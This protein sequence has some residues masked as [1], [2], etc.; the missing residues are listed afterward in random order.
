MPDKLAGG[1]RIVGVGTHDLAVGVRIEIFNGERLHFRKHFLTQLI[2][3]TLRYRRHDSM[4]EESRDDH[5]PVR[6]SHA[7]HHAHE[8]PRDFAQPELNPR[9]D[10]LVDK[11]LHEHR[12]HQTAERVE[13]NTNKHDNHAPLIMLKQ[14]FKQPPERAFFNRA[15]RHGHTPSAHG[16]H[17]AGLLFDRFFLCHYASPPCASL[18]FVCIS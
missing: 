11:R 9:R 16:F 5:D 6:A 18:P 10:N 12:R 14:H 3:H 4:P 7:D 8:F 13:N 15:L 1:V 2:E 17:S